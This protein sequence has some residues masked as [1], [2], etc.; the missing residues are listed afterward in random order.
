VVRKGKSKGKNQKLKIRPSAVVLVGE[1]RGAGPKP[2][3]Q[4]AS[5]RPND[6]QRPKVL[7]L[8]FAFDF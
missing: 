8:I 1:I 6:T 5:Q 4:P 7:F 2:S 3:L